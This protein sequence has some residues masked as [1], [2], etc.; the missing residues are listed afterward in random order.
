MIEIDDLQ[1]QYG[2]KR[3]IFT[4]LNLNLSPGKIYGVIGPN[5]AGKST[6][7]KCICGLLIPKSG[8]VRVAGFTAKDRLPAFLSELFFLPEEISNPNVKPGEYGKF[9]GAF[10]PR[11]DHLRFQSLCEEFEIPLQ[12]KLDEMSYGQKKKTLISFGIACNTNVLLLDE[13]TNGLDIQGK[14][15]FRKILANSTT[16]ENFIII[17]THQIRDIENLIDHI[18]IINE[19]GILFNQSLT[20]ISSALFFAEA[21][22]LNT[23]TSRIYQ[24]E[25][26]HGYSIIEPN[27]GG[28]E[29]RIDLEILYQAILN[30]SQLINQHFK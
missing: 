15:Q 13:P 12:L 21:E 22:E 6:L 19:G 1:Y 29:S 18:L 20:S 25:S 2:T 30:D 23:T 8:K 11:Y 7:L 26:I 24:K 4:G 28:Y 16:P 10:Y 14:S 3:K 17:S 5:G 9:Y 27:P